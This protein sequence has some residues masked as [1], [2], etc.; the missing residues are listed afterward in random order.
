MTQALRVAVLDDYEGAMARHPALQALTGQADITFFDAPLGA[1]APGK[2]NGFDAVCL[3]RERMPMPAALIEALPN[4]RYIAFTGARNPSCDSEAAAARGIPVSTTPG[5]PSKASTAEQTWALLLAAAKQLAP[6][7]YGMRQGKWREAPNGFAYPMAA[8]LESEQLGVIG[9]GAIGE[10]VAR[11]GLAF[12]MDVVAWSQNLTDERAAEVGVRSVDKQAL[13]A[14]SRFVSLHLVLSD[15]SRGII[16]ADDLAQMRRDS[17]LVNTSRAGLID[18]PAL[19]R[20]LKAGQPAHAALDVH[21]S[22]PTAADDPDRELLA[23]NNVTLSPHLGYVAEPIMDAFGRGLAD[24]I[25][26]WLAG[27]PVNVMNRVG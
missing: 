24:V 14:G 16:G 1:A 19:I 21:T 6:A 15:R 9:L 26:G 25:N 8:L 23:L 4:L 11:V 3:I 22:E 2:L 13:L 7:E 17:V 12:G 20:G 18:T 5:G 27:K 10:R